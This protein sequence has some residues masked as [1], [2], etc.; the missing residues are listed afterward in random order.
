MRNLLLLL[1]L[2]NILYFLWEYFQDDN[3]NEPGVAILQESDLGPPLV[4]A[5]QEE[6]VETVAADAEDVADADGRDEPPAAAETVAMAEDENAEVDATPAGDEAPDSSG[7]ELSFALGRTCVTLGPFRQGVDADG[8]QSRYSSEGMK[9]A[10]RMERGE[11]FVGHW[12]QVRNIPDR[13]AGN[14][15]VAALREGGIPEA[16]LVTTDDEGL[17]ISL[18]VFGNRD[19]AERVEALARSLGYPAE[20]TPRTADGVYY[21]VDVA[22]PPG[23]G[24]GAMI[25]RYGEEKV[26][27]REVSSCPD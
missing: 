11:I 17:K 6:P 9:T 12:V 26:R 5:E 4:V 24:A 10:Q 1:L 22:L 20:I 27:M 15:T 18:G 19:G 21:F 13:E 23:R 14:A 8:A 3:A 25:E 16:Y 7:A 2:A